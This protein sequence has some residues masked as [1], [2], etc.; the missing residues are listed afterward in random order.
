[1]FPGGARVRPRLLLAVA[2]ACGLRDRSAALWSGV[3]IEFL[4]CA[5]LVHDDLPCF[6]AAEV[7]RGR[8]SV[9]AAF[10]EELAVLVGDALIVGAFEVIASACTDSPA[11]LPRL[12]GEIAAGVGSATGIVVGQAWES[13]PWV[14][15]P[16]YHRAKTAALFRTCTRVGALAGGGDPDAWTE[17]GER[18][19]E[20]YQ[21]ADD[22]ADVFGREGTVGKPT[23][24]DASLGRPNAVHRLGPTAA[25]V[26]LD[27]ICRGL[28]ASIPAISGAG[29]LV[30]ELERMCTRLSPEAPFV[31]RAPHSRVTA[32]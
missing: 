14:D 28:P 31:P 30:A 25:R 19:G 24:R 1:M 26:R 10:G 15:L 12:I 3:A 4:H 23:R 21:I 6:D 29:G 27:G 5:S 20:A 2:D 16:V 7:R 32:A 8:P 13:E 17:L 9:H 11:L 22:L 18:V